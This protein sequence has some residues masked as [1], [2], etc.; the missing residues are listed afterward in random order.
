MNRTI[1]IV[2]VALVSAACFNEGAPVAE[3]LPT[4][5][6][7]S[8]PQE[9]S[10]TTL[11]GPQ[12]SGVPSSVTCWSSDPGDGESE[13]RFVDITEATGLLD[14]LTG[15]RAH[16]AAWGDVDG[17]LDP[18]LFT[19]TFATARSDVYEVRGADGPSPDRLLLAESGHYD[20]ST[21]FPDE[22]GRTSG[23]VFADLDN[24][25]DDD[26]VLSRNVRDLDI[27]A[28]TTE[29]LENTGMGF[30]AVSTSIDANLGGRSVG[31]LDV[32]GDGLLDFI[33]VE[34]RYRGG[35]SRLYRN[36]GALDFEDATE[37]R[38]VTGVDGLG[39]ATG[40]VNNDGLTDVFVA[41]SNRLFVGDG[42]GLSEV[43]VPDFVWE[44]FGNEDDVAGAAIAD[45][46]R[47]GWL[48][49]V[50]GHHY[51]STLSQGREVPVRLYLNRTKESGDAPLFD[52]VTMEA[53]LVGIP[54][55]AP[56]VEVADFD[57]DGWPDILTSASALSGTAPAIFEHTGLV[58]G[59]PVFAP[60]KGLGSTQYW[61]SA[62][63]VDIDRDGRLDVLLVEWEPSLPSL[64]L[65]N[66]TASGHWLEVSVDASLGGGV[67]TR[68][69]VYEPGRS[70]DPAALIGSRDIVA[71]VGYTAGIE[72][73]AHF[74]LGDLTHVDIVVT[75][76]SPN[77]Q[78]GL[79][80][81]SDQHVRLPS[82][83][84]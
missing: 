11:G 61:V 38:F 46:N 74:G 40:D 50:V 31:V 81:S 72:R 24:D 36:L 71:S 4:S 77:E 12:S 66:E 32:D 53:G 21:D 15:M 62:P 42:D 73:F 9:T 78:I 35:S 22:F 57:N 6:D 2:V 30:A 1:V 28:A 82:G 17:D 52:D 67:G 8:A 34:D 26:L 55:K 51:N 29:V 19:G 39:I 84:R 63:T 48:D 56:H 3:N 76:P 54:T 80:V 70:G 20:V 16:A 83:C 79:E 68:V 49:L 64:M 45:V 69:D 47:D 44:T 14:P 7:S 58:D 60:P 33:V 5:S 41:G 23:A 13:I 43:A 65:A 75:P 27:G 59:I 37:T 18:D 10:P 25:G